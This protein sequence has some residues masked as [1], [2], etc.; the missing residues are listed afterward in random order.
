MCG[1][2]AT[3]FLV[4]PATEIYLII[5]V[6]GWMG[7]WPTLGIVALTAVVGAALTKSQGMAVLNRLRESMAGSGDPGAAITE[8]VLVLAAGITLLAPGFITDAIGLALLIAPIRAVVASKLSG[9]IQMANVAPP[10]V[11]DFG[12]PQRHYEDDDS[13]PPPPGVIDV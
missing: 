2:L 13:D 5:K 4:I 1:L 7:P 6:G 3:L 9:R 12:A 8:G 11:S 10:S